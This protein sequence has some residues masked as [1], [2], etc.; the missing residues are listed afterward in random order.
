MAESEESLRLLITFAQFVMPPAKEVLMTIARSTIMLS[1]KAGVTARDKSQELIDKGISRVDGYGT[2]GNI[3]EHKLIK[4]ATSKIEFF[5]LKDLTRTDIKSLCEAMRKRG[6]GISVVQTPEGN[7]GVLCEAKNL[8]V[9][10]AAALTVIGRL[11]TD[12]LDVKYNAQKEEA[13]VSLADVPLDPSCDMQE[14]ECAGYTWKPADTQEEMF[15]AEDNNLKLCA[16]NRGTWAVVHKDTNEPYVSESGTPLI[17]QIKTEAAR[18]LVQAEQ[19]AATYAAYAKN[20]VVQAQD[21]AQKRLTPIP[22]ETAEHVSS[23]VHEAALE[24]NKK[25][26]RSQKQVHP[27][28][29]KM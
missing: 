13:E 19:A 21:S 15:C 26:S 24:I 3:S 11:V 14:H 2:S 27:L 16:D 10:R 25:L 7:F 1:K 12:D 4:N 20:P 8:E 17:G 5:E 18:P 22:T 9:L 29:R 28:T 23:A 6:V